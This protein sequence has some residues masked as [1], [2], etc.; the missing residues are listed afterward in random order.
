M[1]EQ[2]PKVSLEDQDT[3][4]E[5]LCR[6]ARPGFNVSCRADDLLLPLLLLSHSLTLRVCAGRSVVYFHLW[7]ST[8]RNTAVTPRGAGTRREKENAEVQMQTQTQTRTRTRT[9]KSPLPCLRLCLCLRLLH[10]RCAH[11]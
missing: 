6:Y 2:R 3:I 8:A 11:M 1:G 7:G 9:Q 10:L 4:L 5:L